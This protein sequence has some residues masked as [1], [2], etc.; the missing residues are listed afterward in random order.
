V[1]LAEYQR[2]MIADSFALEPSAQG[3][4]ALGNP[5]RFR[6]YRH[7]I[8]TRLLGMAQVAFK[9]SLAICGERPFAACFERHLAQHPPRSPLIRDVIAAFGEYARAD[10]ELLAGAP[11][12]L[13]DML[14]F[15]LAKWTLAYW[16]CVRPKLGEGGVR[17]LDF[18]G[19]LVLNPVLQ[20]LRLAHPVHTALAGEAIAEAETELLVYRPEGV[21]EV[22]WYVAE[23]LFAGIVRRAAEAEQTL[24]GLV[25]SVAEQQGRGLDEE[26][27]Q[28][29]A[30]SLTLAVQ[31]GVVVGVR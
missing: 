2:A 13:P 6:L 1:N 10:R 19:A 27:L 26:L 12:E 21:D 7:M 3:E 31:R 30:S 9:Q 15:E 14:C 17:E 18:E 23:P 16:P 22:R 11:L 28:T 8:R 25:R 20:L 24:A 5:E 29:L 4:L